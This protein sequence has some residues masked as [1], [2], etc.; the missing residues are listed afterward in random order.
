MRT[1]SIA[2]ICITVMLIITSCTGN[3][4]I[5]SQSSGSKPRQIT[6]VADTQN[7]VNPGDT[8]II[9][10]EENRTTQY[11]WYFGVSDDDILEVTSDDFSLKSKNSDGGGGKRTITFLAISSGETSV[12]MSLM[13]EMP[14]PYE[15]NEDDFASK[16][17][18]YPI[19]VK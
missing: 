18:T 10:V 16:T 13:V 11:R 4:T 17:L 2:A 14:E 8:L 7:E 1:I 9:V 15:Y 5:T 6:L 19:T 12:R 3:T